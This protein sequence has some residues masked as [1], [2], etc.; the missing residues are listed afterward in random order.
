MEGTVM[1]LM[2]LV[3]TTVGWGINNA[4]ALAVGA[5][6]GPVIS[7]AGLGLV[8]DVLG[9]GKDLVDGTAAFVSKK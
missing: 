7:K 4:L 1:D 2:G 9:R 6:L 3:G 8:G 5:V